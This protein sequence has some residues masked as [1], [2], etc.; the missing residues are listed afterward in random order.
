MAYS[1]SILSLFS[2]FNWGNRDDHP[3]RCFAKPV[4]A[5]LGSASLLFGTLPVLLNLSLE[6]STHKRLLFI[7]LFALSFLAFFLVP[8]TKRQTVGKFEPYKKDKYN[9]TYAKLRMV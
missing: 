9:R 1:K 8:Q 5:A 6:D 3:L 2:N 4:L 7:C